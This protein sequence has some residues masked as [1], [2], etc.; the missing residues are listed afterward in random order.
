MVI[1]SA[2]FSF[3]FPPPSSLVVS[4]MSVISLVSLANAGFSEI[5]GKH[6]NYSKFW[7][8]NPSAEKQ[9][10]LSSK[11]GMLLLYTPAFLAGL[12]SF[13]I[14]PHQGLRSTLLQSAVTLHF[15]KRVF[16]VV[17][18]HK[19]SGAMLLDSAIP[20]T[21]SYF[22]STATMI[23]AQHL[24]QGLPEPPIDLLYPGIVLFVVGII[25]N[26]YHHYLLSN[27]R[28]KG[29]KEY[30]IP[31]GGMFELVICPHYLFE[32]I[33]FYGFSF[34]SQTLYAFSFTV[35]TTLYLLGRSYSTR[36]WYLSKFEDFPEH[37]KAII[38]FVF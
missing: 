11:A 17:F 25:G 21:L 30:K 23:Y 9:V 19:Y 6:L 15:F 14:F 36:K 8:A 3:I 29:E 24:T 32:I 20:I 38:P 12:A 26:F 28:G 37:V 31:K 1:M 4:G 5:R 33:E 16:E 22:L 7:N 13:W 34:I 35:G 18:I 27:L 2:L 10:K